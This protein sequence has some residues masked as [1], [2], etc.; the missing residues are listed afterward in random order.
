MDGKKKACIVVASEVTIRAFLCAQIKAMQEDYDVTVVLNTKRLDLLS[1][2]G[3]DGRVVPV[4][5]E[6]DISLAK[7]LAAL[8]E[9]VRLFRRERFDVVHSVT[10][11]AGLLAM[12]GGLLARVPTRVH[13]FTGQMWAT[14]SGASRA[15]F[16][17][18]DR[19]LAACATYVLVDSPSQR[20]F[21]LR[22][23][24]VGPAKSAVLGKGSVSGVD[25]ERF[26]PNAD[27]RRR[28]REQLGIPKRDVV[29]LFLGRLNRDK[30]LLDLAQAFA[31]VAADHANVHLV[32]VGQDEH[33]LTPAIRRACAVYASRLHLVDFTLEP[34][35][36]VAAADILCLPSYR[37]GFGNCVIEAAAAGLPAVASRI[38]GVVDAVEEGVTGLL[39]PPRDIDALTDVLVRMVG[40]AS[41]RE[42]LAKAALERARREFSQAVLTRQ[43]L[44][45][46]ARMLGEEPR[47]TDYARPA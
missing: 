13:T 1:E 32:V 41:L 38:Y 27:A 45:T 16:K 5:I 17:N 25:A 14:R 20:D 18:L 31:R 8:G 23:R 2:L 36:F 34:E 7:D 4:G 30:G 6:R 35:A 11:K 37:E 43:L 28:I 42:R 15:L 29:L 19:V 12:T 26:R 39:H 44:D 33:E 10:P 47:R 22:E 3:L 40:D 21:L 9:L 46:Y 24:V